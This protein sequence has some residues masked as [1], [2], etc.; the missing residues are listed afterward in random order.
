MTHPQRILIVGG[1]AGIGAALT[2]SIIRKSTAQVFV[3]DK[4]IDYASDGPLG[5][6]LAYPNRMYGHEGDVTVPEERE[7]AIETCIRRDVLGGIDTVVYCAGIITPI[8]RVEKMNIAAVEGTYAVNVFG[9]MAMARTSTFSMS[10]DLICPIGATRV[11]TSSSCPA[12]SPSQLWIRQDHLSYICMRPR[13]HVPWLE[14]LLHIQG[15]I[16][17]LHLVSRA[18]GARH[19]RARRIPETDSNEN[20]RGRRFGPIPGCHGGSRGREVQDVG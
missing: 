7:H 6:L 14:S 12:V 15:C 18:R 8:E 1:A 10:I 11:A 16:D 17:A 20:A 13:S 4:N 2:I 3:F 5:E 19:Q 9:A